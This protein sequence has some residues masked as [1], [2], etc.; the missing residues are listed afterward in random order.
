MRLHDVTPTDLREI[1][2][3][4]WVLE[5]EPHYYIAGVVDVSDNP[6]ETECEMLDPADLTTPDF[7]SIYY[8]DEEGFSEIVEDFP[9]RE[10]ALAYGRNHPLTHN[11]EIYDWT[12]QGYWG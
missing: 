4:V 7:W 6:D 3:G 1:F 8:R 11:V 12:L 5:D 9:T 2:P 10:A